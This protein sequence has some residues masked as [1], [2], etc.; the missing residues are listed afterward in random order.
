M[1]KIHYDELTWAAIALAVAVMSL[2]SIFHP[3]SS[4]K[5]L[6]IAIA[7]L[8]LTLNQIFEIL[9]NESYANDQ[10][11]SRINIIALRRKKSN[12]VRQI[13]SNTG[14]NR[15]RTQIS[16]VAAIAVLIVGFSIDFE[17]NATSTIDTI[18]LLSF[19]LMFISMGLNSY[20]TRHMTMIDEALDILEE[21]DRDDQDTKTE[22]NIP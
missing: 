11:M 16:Y 9:T 14:T 20:I 1:K 19:S 5:M 10:V 22:D 13:K 12:E 6:V 17:I 18:T 7:A 8:L 15:K 21:P 4:W 3:F 2:I